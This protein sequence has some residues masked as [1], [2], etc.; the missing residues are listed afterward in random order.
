MGGRP[1][2][3]RHPVMAGARFSGVGGWRP[4]YVRSGV[5]DAFGVSHTEIRFLPGV[6]SKVDCTL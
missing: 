1:S 5:G 2:Q 3:L 4:T 6:R